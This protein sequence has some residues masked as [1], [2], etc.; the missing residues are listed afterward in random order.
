MIDHISFRVRDFDASLAF[1]KA[2]LAPLGYSVLMSFPG[3]AGLGRD[4]KPDLWIGAGAAD[5]WPAGS[6]VGASPLHIAISADDKAAVDAF[7]AAAIAAGATDH[8]AP[9]MRPQYHPGYYG[10]FVVD[11][12]GHNLEAVCHRAG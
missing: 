8:G 2:A 1:Y 3:I 6:V 11:P 10:A 5:Y 12:N 7:Y 4:G 9:G